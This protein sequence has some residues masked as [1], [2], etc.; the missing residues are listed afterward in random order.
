MTVRGCQRGG[1]GALA[2]VLDSDTV[3]RPEIEGEADMWGPHVSKWTKR[4]S[5]GILG[6]TEA[7]YGYGGL[8]EGPG[9][10]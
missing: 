8:T 9:T 10:Q 7:A 3:R 1:H 5:T 4:S 2:L 6:H